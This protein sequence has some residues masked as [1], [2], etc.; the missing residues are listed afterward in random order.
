[1]KDP[2]ALPVPIRFNTI[3]TGTRYGLLEP[4]APIIAMYYPLIITVAIGLALAAMLLISKVQ[5]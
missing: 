3:F 4:R 2:L 1:M 5:E